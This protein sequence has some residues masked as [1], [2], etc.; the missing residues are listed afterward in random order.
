MRVFLIVGLLCS[1]ILS[2]KCQELNPQLLDSIY[3]YLLD[4]KEAALAKDRTRLEQLVYISKDTSTMDYHKTMVDF[5]IKN[6]AYSSG[7]FSFSI[8]ALNILIDSL[9]NKFQPIPEEIR[10]M[11]NNQ[12]DGV[13]R[14]ATLNLENEEIPIFDF[15]MVHIILLINEENE[16]KLLFWENLNRL[17]RQ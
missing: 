1:I 14:R 15:K 9:Y 12:P 4:F 6:D 11:L 13:F 7:D 10:D 5:V 8:E 16:I 17:R 3:K 2:A